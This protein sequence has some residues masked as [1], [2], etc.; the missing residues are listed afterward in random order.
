MRPVLVL[1]AVVTCMLLLILGQALGTEMP[2][3]SVA[4]SEAAPAD[5]I[6]ADSGPAES[7]SADPALANPAPADSGRAEGESD[8]QSHGGTDGEPSQPD[9]SLSGQAVAVRPYTASKSLRPPQTLTSSS[10]RTSRAEERSPD[11]P[12]SDTVKLVISFED[13]IIGFDP[14]GVDFECELISGLSAN[15]CDDGTSEIAFLIERFSGYSVL[16]G[17]E[18]ET[19]IRLPKKEERALRKDDCDRSRARFVPLSASS[20]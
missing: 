17:S 6:P 12:D 5:I 13:S 18:G 8:A 16:K 3:G 14:A 9:D 7:N 15:R 2:A 1:I 10:D 20:R 11:S 4:P 19:V